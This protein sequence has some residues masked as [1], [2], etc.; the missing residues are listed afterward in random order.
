MPPPRPVDHSITPVLSS[1]LFLSP[2]FFPSLHLSSPPS[3][4]V[5]DLVGEETVL[6][7]LEVCLVQAVAAVD[8]LLVLRGPLAVLLAAGATC[9]LRI[10]VLQH[11][12]DIGLLLWGEGGRVEGG[13]E[14]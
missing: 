6:P 12:G 9:L 7:G 1:P 3:W 13:R 11:V 14:E 4:S 2:V 8:Q 10:G 5:V